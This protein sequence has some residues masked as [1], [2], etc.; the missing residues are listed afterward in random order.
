MAAKGS[1]PQQ[2]W[3]EAYEELMVA[4]GS[5]WMWWFGNDFKS[6]EDAVF[7]SLFRRHI[8][9][10]YQLLNLPAPQDLENPIKKSLT[11]RLGV[12]FQA[13]TPQD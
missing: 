13:P 8:G 11:G 10:I 2:Q 9:N 12:M 6:D 3:S 1:T 5:D 7:D 4:E